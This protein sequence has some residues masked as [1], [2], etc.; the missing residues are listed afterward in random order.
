MSKINWIDTIKKL[1]KYGFK[2]T[3]LSH[4]SHLDN[5]DY[6]D[7]SIWKAEVA[8]DGTITVKNFGYWVSCNEW[9]VIQWL[10]KNNIGFIANG[11]YGHVTYLFH[12]NDKYL[13]VFRNYGAQVETYHYNKSWEEI[14]KEWKM[15]S[16]GEEQPYY[17]ISVKDALKD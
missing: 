9:D 15:Y 11:H 10:V 2:E 5:A 8:K 7:Q 1:L 14:V 17:R 3:H 4:P 16:V 6:D 12:K 13:M